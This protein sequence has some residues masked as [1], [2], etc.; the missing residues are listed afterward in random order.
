MATPYDSLIHREAVI[1]G[2]DPDLVAAV[3]ATESNFKPDAVSHA[4]ARGLMQLMPNTA[5]E[6][7]VNPDD[8]EQNVRGGTR[9]LKKMLDRY[10]GNTAMA[11]A[12]YNAGAR[13]VDRHGGI[14]PFPETQGYVSK[15]MGK[16]NKT[17][18]VSEPLV[19]DPGTVEWYLRNVKERGKQGGLP[20][21]ERS[22]AIV[23]P[24]SVDDTGSH[25]FRKAMEATAR[26]ESSTLNA[27][28]GALMKGMHEV[29]SL[30]TSIPSMLP[31]NPS[32]VPFKALDAF[33][34]GKITDLIRPQFI[35]T[36]PAQQELDKMLAQA[37]EVFEGSD[38][39]EWS[40]FVAEWVPALFMGAHA[41][42]WSRKA[43]MATAPMLLKTMGQRQ[44]LN[45]FST[46]AGTAM[47][48]AGDELAT[49]AMRRAKGETV[50]AIPALERSLMAIGNGMGI[51][52]F[53]AI[54]E[55]SQTGNLETSLKHGAAIAATGA[56]GEMALVGAGRILFPSFRKT[57]DLPK[58]RERWAKVGPKLQADILAGDVKALRARGQAIYLTPRA[59]GKV[60]FLT[61]GE[62]ALSELSDEGA[63]ELA[64]GFNDMTKLMTVA[65]RSKR[66]KQVAKSYTEYNINGLS[67]KMGIFDDRLEGLLEDEAL[68]EISKAGIRKTIAGRRRA[69][70]A[71]A[72]KIH[73]A[74]QELRAAYNNTEALNFAITVEPNLR[75][76]LDDTPISPQLLLE[77]S[78]NVS[79]A[80]AISAAGKWLSTGKSPRSMDV[81]ARQG[82]NALN[83]TW[84]SLNANLL[85]AH[86]LNWL[87][88]PG[89]VGRR[90]GVAGLKFVETHHQ[91]QTEA[92]L[93]MPKLHIA[94]DEM[95]EKLISLL[96]ARNPKLIT[97]DN[98][99]LRPIRNAYEHGGL[100]Q[101][102]AEFGPEV[103]QIW[104]K[105]VFRNLDWLGKAN[106]S[107]GNNFVM[108]DSE[109]QLLGVNSYF[110][111]VVK[112]SLDYGKLEKQF[113]NSLAL[114]GKSD[115]EI[116]KIIT[117]GGWR[118]DGAQKFGTI[119]Q[120]RMLP[121]T[122]DQKLA[123]TYG[124]PSGKAKV[125][126]PLEDDPLV[127]LKDHMDH[128]VTRY[129]LGK[130]FGPNFEMGS[131]FKAAIMDEGGSE[132]AAN[133]LVNSALFQD[134]PNQFAAKLAANVTAYQQ[135][136][137]LSWAALPN[138]FQ[139]VMTGIRLG[140]EATTKAIIASNKDLLS[141]VRM[142]KQ[143]KG[144]LATTDKEVIA[145]TLGFLEKSLLSS[146][147]IFEGSR[148]KTLMEG[149]SDYAL[150]LY[151]FT[152]T[153]RM[154]RMIAGHAALMDTRLTLEKIANGKL[155]GEAYGHARRGLDSLG[156]NIDQ[157]M[158]R[159][160][161]TG[162]LGLTPEQLDSVIVNGVKQTQFSTGTMDIPPKWRTPA[163]RVIMQ[164]KSFAFNAGRLVRDQ[165]LR[166]FDQGNYKPFLYA[167]SLG[168]ITGEAVGLTLDL[169][170]GR[171][172]SAPN[173]PWRILED[174]SNWG[175]LGLAKSVADGALYGRTLETFAGPT[176]SDIAGIGIT[177]PVQAM[178][179]G[180]PSKALKPFTRQPAPQL[181][182]RSME[183]GAGL[184]DASIDVFESGWDFDF[185]PE[186]GEQP[187][188]A[189]TIED[190]MKQMRESKQDA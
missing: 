60:D 178:A 71:K 123:G 46:R 58:L 95:N 182:K 144:T 180:K 2:V 106:R 35:G 42:S 177:G 82:A 44:L 121:G 36:G 159:Y 135:V 120:Q 94:L 117:E 6:L 173:G 30:T 41:A 57:V 132:A 20:E 85:E 156:I 97:K 104:E 86:R 108:S 81:M 29:G 105:D 157:V 15:V 163:G 188:K 110:P 63:M 32:N 5:K 111:Q 119:D 9:Y 103:T 43:L 33:A 3:V 4:G 91:A 101:V 67:K 92:R 151:Q 38:A 112:K 64:D 88:S 186:I 80:I 73:K 141:N 161:A 127:A 99:H 172:S 129:V 50:G 83:R 49:S 70:K 61:K 160:N 164:F 84:L 102:E 53:E 155:R 89:G 12:A 47:A 17:K 168:G 28:T 87:E 66:L 62:K 65:E 74:E 13:N 69:F 54:R 51:G 25:A 114:Q 148:P 174:L 185:T 78:R 116:T 90:V 158:A 162:R 115:R 124:T 27:V 18:T 113:A 125:G 154:N 146:K 181:F 107:V 26:Q 133:Q 48:K 79:D 56:V 145:Q 39:Y 37:D 40:R 77:R 1:Q 143:F 122:T 100:K 118:R 72:N 169:V 139:S 184:L 138:A 130:R 24:T 31:L 171:P 109:L 150:R 14:P 134:I 34:S 147:T 68:E 22:K 7:G 187:T 45:R 176:M 52:G 59:K 189:M 165:I 175:G 21:P 55:L 149:V 167:M 179:T 16:L 75:M 126:I 10:D 152:R 131:A 190:H 140:P 183:I 153:E 11:L 166:E 19:A 98:A 76:A 142:M 137:K 96:K 23:E 128:S 8:P 136:A 93:I 170:K